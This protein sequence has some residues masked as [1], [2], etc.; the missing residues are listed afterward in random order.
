MQ[1]SKRFVK[2]GLA[3]VAAGA[4]VAGVIALSGPAWAGFISKPVSSTENNLTIGME[5]QNTTGGVNMCGA[6]KDA[7]SSGTYF[8]AHIE[9]L[10]G[11]NFV[12]NSPE[13]QAN[14]GGQYWPSSSSFWCSGVAIND[15]LSQEAILWK[16]S[17]SN[18]TIVSSVSD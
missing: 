1:R 18:H 12:A 16:D 8:S 17:G 15:G 10:N 6:E 14:G 2:V 5:D 7:Q 13:F 11:G 3:T 9:L 4:P